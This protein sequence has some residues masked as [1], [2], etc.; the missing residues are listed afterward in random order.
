MSAVWKVKLGESWTD[1]YIWRDD[2]LVNT[3]V[4]IEAKLLLRE[5]RWWGFSMEAEGF[6]VTATG[7]YEDGKGLPSIHWGV[8]AT[9]KQLDNECRIPNIEI[10]DRL[11]VYGW[12]IEG[13]GRPGDSYGDWRKGIPVVG[14]CDD[15]CGAVLQVERQTVRPRPLCIG[16]ALTDGRIVELLEGGGVAELRDSR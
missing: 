9:C 8:F 7:A 10:G 16:D 6:F 11:I 12:H 5:G 2:E 3:I 4:N 14:H 1:T 15:L 13:G